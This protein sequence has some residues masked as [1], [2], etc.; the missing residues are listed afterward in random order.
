MS[1]AE[2]RERM[3]RDLSIFLQAEA[4]AACFGR[5]GF[6]VLLLLQHEGRRRRRRRRQQRRKLTQAVRQ[7]F[8][9][10]TTATQGSNTTN[11]MPASFPWNGPVGNRYPENSKMTPR[12]FSIWEK[13]C[14]EIRS[15][16][17]AFAAMNQ[18]YVLH[19]HHR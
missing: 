8:L 13:C 6:L 15:D 9:G 7:H 17:K 11:K 10:M 14:A 3:R 16:K 19:F 1:A 12:I 2:G 4:A 18:N 5:G